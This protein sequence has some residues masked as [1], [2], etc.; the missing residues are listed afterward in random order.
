ML[1]RSKSFINEGMILADTVKLCKM[2]ILCIEI[3]N[4]GNII[5][6]TIEVNVSSKSIILRH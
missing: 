6:P 3:N 1:T 4:I 5:L 2:F